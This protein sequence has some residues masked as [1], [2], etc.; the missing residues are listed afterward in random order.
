M[1]SEWI[2]GVFGAG[3]AAI[4]AAATIAANLVTGR[5]Q[6]KLEKAKRGNTNVDLRRTVCTEYLSTVYSFMDKA[7]EVVRTTRYQASEQEIEAAHDAYLLEWEKVHQRCAPVKI[8]G[9]LELRKSA[10]SVRSKLAAIG[11]VADEHYSAHQQGNP[12]RRAGDITHV[13]LAAGDT[14]EEFVTL[15]SEHTQEREG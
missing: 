15:A 7:R 1:A 2:T 12:R 9:P 3:G 5:N 10:E 8:V 6:A 4:G 11:G 14:V 13:L